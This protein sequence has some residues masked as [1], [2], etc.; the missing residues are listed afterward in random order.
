MAVCICS[1]KDKTRVLQPSG[2]EI[3][4]KKLM[5]ADKTYIRITGVVI[6]DNKVRKLKEELV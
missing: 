3:V 2:Y 6:T 1:C 4:G 5:K